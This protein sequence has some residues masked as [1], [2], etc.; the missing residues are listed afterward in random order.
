MD[1]AWQRASDLEQPRVEIGA[2][3]RAAFQAE[4]WAARPTASTRIKPPHRLP[5]QSTSNPSCIRQVGDATLSYVWCHGIMGRRT[6]DQQYD[7]K[8]ATGVIMASKN[9][10]RCVKET[11]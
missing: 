5:L 6:E 1:L 2:N 10:S 3:A 4:G 8:T 11:L 7:A 9:W